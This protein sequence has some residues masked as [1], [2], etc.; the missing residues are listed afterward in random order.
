MSV[1]SLASI[2]A[3]GG[4]TGRVN[5]LPAAEKASASIYFRRV[6]QPEASPIIFGAGLWRCLETAFLVFMAIGALAGISYLYK[7][8]L[9]FIRRRA[10]GKEG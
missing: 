2:G 1:W 7:P 9:N 6:Q 4:W 10:R 5:G 8:I 3:S